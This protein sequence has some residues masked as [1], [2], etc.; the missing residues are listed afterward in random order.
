MVHWRLTHESF[1]L[2]QTRGKTLDTREDDRRRVIATSP[3]FCRL[4]HPLGADRI[5]QNYK[6]VSVSLDMGDNPLPRMEGYACWL[7]LVAQGGITRTRRHVD[8]LSCLYNM[9]AVSEAL[10]SC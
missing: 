8:K 9:C 1:R 3:L 5:L 4:A 2:V 10:C 6:T 7:T